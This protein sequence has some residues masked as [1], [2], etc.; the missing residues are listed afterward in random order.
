MHFHIRYDGITT[1]FGRRVARCR[2]YIHWSSTTRGQAGRRIA[3]FCI[4]GL[5]RWAYFIF[6]VFEPDSCLLAAAQLDNQTKHIEEA[7]LVRECRV[8][9]DGHVD[10]ELGGGGQSNAGRPEVRRPPF[11]D[12]DRSWAPIVGDW[13]GTAVVAAVIRYSCDSWPVIGSTWQR[14]A[15]SPSRL[16]CRRPCLL[17]SWQ[18]EAVCLP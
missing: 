18:N 3:A 9:G 2:R 17:V 11:R 15:S 14:R 12:W 5:L 7:Q 1:A 16:H 4:G 10:R 13:T 8:L 6:V